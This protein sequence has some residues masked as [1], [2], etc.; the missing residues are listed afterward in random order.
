[1]C[2][3]KSSLFDINTNPRQ[4]D[5]VVDGAVDQDNGKMEYNSGK[6]AIHVKELR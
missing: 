3:V 4:H 6:L 1:M 5:D 2:V